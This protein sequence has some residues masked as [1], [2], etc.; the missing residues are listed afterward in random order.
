V[1]EGCLPQ[2]ASNGTVFL[3]ATS[4]NKLLFRRFLDRIEDRDQANLPPAMEMAFSQY[5]TTK[6]GETGGSGKVGN[7]MLL[8]F[9]G[10]FEK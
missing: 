10:Q 6:T 3:P 8:L 1:L 7:K 2:A 5:G 4:G 9:T